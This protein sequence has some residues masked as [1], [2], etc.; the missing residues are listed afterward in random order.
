VQGQSVP[1]YDENTVKGFAKAFSGWAYGGLDNTKPSAFHNHDENDERLWRVPMIAWPMWHS[2]GTKQLL[3]GTVL[4]AGQSAEKDMADAL[5]NIFNHPNVGPFFARQM[6]QRLVTSNPSAD[7]VRRVATVF[8]NNGAGV[9]GDLKAVIKAVLLDAEARDDTQASNPRFG[10]QREPVLRL[11][12]FLRGLNASSANGRNSLHY[13]DSSDDALGQSPLL[14]PSVFNFYSPAYRP[15]GPLAQAGLVAPE[16]QITS[17]T[18]VVG[19][20][21]FFASLFN[22]AGYGWDDSKLNFNYEPLMALAHDAAALVERL[23][24][25]FFCKQMSTNSKQRLTTLVGA[26]TP[27]DRTGRVKA[28]L[29]LTAMSPDFVIQK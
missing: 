24:L 18:T 14:A 5:D 16:F 25:L 4:P 3:N 2:T 22:N 29:L 26:M 12:A 10:K 8:N 27:N 6:I 1:T 11:A 20:L 19:S 15:A 17:E 21:N 9:R 23:D 7:Y 13:L 28:A